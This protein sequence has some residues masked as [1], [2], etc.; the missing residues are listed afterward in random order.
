MTDLWLRAAA[1]A[2]TWSVDDKQTANMSR[3]NDSPVSQS[4]TVSKQASQ[5]CW[6]YFY[7][8]TQFPGNEKITLCNH[9]KVQKS[10]WTE[11]YSSCSFTTLLCSKMALYRWIKTECRWNKKPI[12]VWSPDWSASLRPSLER[13]ARPNALI[14]PN[15]SM[16]TGWKMLCA[17]MFEYFADLRMAAS[18]AAEPA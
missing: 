13:K 16:A 3:H 17:W 14:G 4:Q 18:F 1:A 6:N 10:S 11:P 12:S 5:S 15:D 7:S 9:K 2:V 8:G